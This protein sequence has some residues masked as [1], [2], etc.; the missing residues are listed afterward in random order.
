MRSTASY[1]S[2]LEDKLEEVLRYEDSTVLTPAEKAVVA[3]ALAAGSVPN[4]AEQTHF[5]ALA[6]HFNERQIAQIVAVISLFGFLNRWNDTMATQL[7]PN[8]VGFASGQLAAFG[9]EQGKHA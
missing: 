8:P 1:L 2:E 9:W 4:G 5:D 7:E 3:L 6:E